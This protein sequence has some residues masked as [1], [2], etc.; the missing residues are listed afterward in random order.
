[1]KAS[2]AGEGVSPALQRLI[3]LV[4]KAAT[5]KKLRAAAAAH[6]KAAAAAGGV[7]R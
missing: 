2:D 6:E 1:M 4:A 3:K 7:R 5:R